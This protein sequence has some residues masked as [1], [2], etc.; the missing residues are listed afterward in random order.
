MYYLHFLILSQVIFSDETY[1]DLQKSVNSQFVRREANARVTTAHTRN[2]RPFLQRALFWG[3]FSGDQG[4]GP[5]VF[6]DGTMKT[7]TY[8]YTLQHHLLPFWQQHRPRAGVIF[9]HDNA[10]CHKSSA[11]QAFLT[12]N[13]I[14]VLQWPAYSPDLNPIENMWGILKRKIH[15]QIYGS[16]EELRAAVEQAWQDPS[17]SLVCQKLSDSMCERISACISAKGGFISY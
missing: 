13:R 14:R 16:K 8:K 3:C 11:T 6:V 4:Q 2:R 12:E 9:Q 1:F 7:A 15:R 10:P 17:V 5:L